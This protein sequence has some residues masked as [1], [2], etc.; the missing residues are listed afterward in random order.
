MRDIP[1]ILD[2]LTLILGIYGINNKGNKHREFYVP[3]IKLE[4]V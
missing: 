2:L 4:A 3:Y 1:N